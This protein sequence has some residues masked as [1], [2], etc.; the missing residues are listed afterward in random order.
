[1]KKLIL[2]S[3]VTLI[4]STHALAADINAGKAKAMSCAGCHSGSGKPGISL[5]ENFPNL[6]GQKKS[7][8]VKQ[9]KDFKSGARKDP[10][11]QGMAAALSEQDM[12][13]IAAFFSSQK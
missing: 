11:M 5:S 7:Y 8:L 12:I 10:I 9:L 1:M 13:N 2:I 6:A 4:A 3:I